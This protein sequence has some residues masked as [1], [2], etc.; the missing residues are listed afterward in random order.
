MN[1]KLLIKAVGF[2]VLVMLA[3]GFA[4]L[5]MAWT[6]GLFV[7]VIFFCITVWAIYNRLKWREHTMRRKDRKW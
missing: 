5:L 7:L 3:L 6:K 4:A 1:Y 2:A